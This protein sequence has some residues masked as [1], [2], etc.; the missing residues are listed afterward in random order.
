MVELKKENI[1]EIVNLIKQEKVVALPTDTIYGFSCLPTSN[2]AVKKL[3]E[4]KKCSDEKLFIILVSKNYDLNNLAVLNED[5]K[6]FISNNT[7]NPVT[8][9]LQKNKN[10]KLAKNFYAPTI[11]IRVPDNEFLQQILSEVGFMISTSCNV[12]GQ[13]N[14]TNFKDIKNTFSNLDAI[15]E[16]DLVNYNSSSTIV[17]LTTKDF[18]ILRQGNYVVK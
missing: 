6:N 1:S 15:V 7:P 9:I 17:D 13:A 14:L 12:H 11:A 18:K 8:M 5:V 2:K 16:C 4:L 3:C 10:L